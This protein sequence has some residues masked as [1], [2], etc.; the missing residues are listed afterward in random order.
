MIAAILEH[1]FASC[2]I[3]ATAGFWTI[4]VMMTWQETRCEHNRRKVTYTTGP[5]V[6]TIT[7]VKPSSMMA[8][9]HTLNGVPCLNRLPCPIHGGSI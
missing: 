3:F 8:C 2:T 6:E 9:H 7:P 4:L 1:W 5:V